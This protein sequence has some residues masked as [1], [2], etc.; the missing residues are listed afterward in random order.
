MATQFQIEKD[1]PIPENRGSGRPVRY[2]L[3][4]M[5]PGDSLRVALADSGC[6]NMASL[7]TGLRT[8]ARSAWGKGNCVTR[9]S[10]DGTAIR[11]WRLA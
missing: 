11:I 1:I 8:C 5:Q 7:Q 4:E 2:P 9:Q 10:D 6:K 3:R